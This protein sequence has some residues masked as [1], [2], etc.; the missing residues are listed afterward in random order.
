[1]LFSVLCFC[2]VTDVGVITNA[3]NVFDLCELHVYLCI[4]LCSFGWWLSG[5]LAICGK[6]FNVGHCAQ[7]FGLY[8]FM[9]LSVALT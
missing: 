8:H 6:Y 7:T 4:Q 1:M 2:C 5:W 9:P 3:E